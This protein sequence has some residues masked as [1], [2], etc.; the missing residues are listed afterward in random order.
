MNL[1]PGWCKTDLGGP[2]ATYP[3]EEGAKRI[4]AGL[5]ASEMLPD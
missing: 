4:Y 5:V 1:Y 2:K 3:V